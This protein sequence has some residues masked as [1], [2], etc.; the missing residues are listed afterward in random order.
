MK[1]VHITTDVVISS[2]N[3]T[4]HH[5]ITD[6]VLKVSLNTITVTFNVNKNRRCYRLGVGYYH[7]IEASGA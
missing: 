7:P 2:T 6:I 5:D 3:K 4:D 1:S